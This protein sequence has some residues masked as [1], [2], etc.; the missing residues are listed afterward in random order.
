[1]PQLGFLYGGLTMGMLL[2]VPMIV[3]GSI[4]M[5]LAWR[6]PPRHAA[7]SPEPHP[8]KA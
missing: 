6:K 4:L 3:V 7:V 8:S 1:D 2:S 5:V